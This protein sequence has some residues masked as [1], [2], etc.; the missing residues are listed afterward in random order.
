ME[1]LYQLSYVGATSNPS[2]IVADAD[3]IRARND[4]RC[5]AVPGGVFLPVLGAFQGRFWPGTS[6]SPSRQAP[7]T[8]QPR[9]TANSEAHLAIHG[10]AGVKGSSPFVGSHFL[11]QH[12]RSSVPFLST[13]VLSCPQD[14]DDESPALEPKMALY[15]AIGR[16]WGASHGKHGVA[17]PNPAVGSLPKRPVAGLDEVGWLSIRGRPVRPG[18]AARRPPRGPV[19]PE[20]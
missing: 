13:V 1:V 15:L 9:D 6:P 8:Q 4:H 7:K 2:V 20:L 19:G 3:M 17:G 11:P 10:K 16:P 14:E 12:H 5:P 18:S